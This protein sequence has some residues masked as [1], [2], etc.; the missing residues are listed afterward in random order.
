MPQSRKGSLSRKGDGMKF[1]Y[2]QD[3]Q[4]GGQYRFTTS[5]DKPFQN[6]DCPSCGTSAH[7][8]DPL[9]VSV[10]AERL[11]DRSKAELDGS[12]NTLAILLAA[13]AVETF[14]TRLFLKLKGMEHFATGFVWTTSADEALWEKEYPRSGGFPGPANFVSKHIVQ[15]TFD[16]FV[17]SNQ[18]AKAIYSALPYGNQ[19]PLSE[20]CQSELF[21][22]RNRIAHWGYINST[23]DDAKRCYDIGLAVVRVLRE[24]DKVRYANV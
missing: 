8:I 24:M 3:C 23:A 14:L 11:L 5:G 1:E 4:C 17:S 15:T 22:L 9:S 18:A 7:L 19:L 2:F 10:V 12:D 16:E 21:N 6:G 20:L 13:I